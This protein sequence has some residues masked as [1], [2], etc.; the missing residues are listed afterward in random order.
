MA[1]EPKPASKR[2][3]KNPETFRERA[4]KAS[5][6]GDKPKRSLKAA[7]GKV[8]KPVAG[9][10]GRAFS[11]VWNAVPL[12]WL[13]KPARILGKIVFPTYFRQ[14]WRELKQVHWPSWGESRRL[15]FAVLI[16][17]V[18]FG[19]LVAGVD[20]GLDKAFRNFLLK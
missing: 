5:T 9:P 2:R 10:I 15:T 19:A 18:I 12:K 7:G 20:Y 6:E 11:K 13:H 4:L 3:V 16:F 8:T 1:D 14:S 17:A